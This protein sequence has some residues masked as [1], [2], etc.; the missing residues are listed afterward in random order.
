[1]AR[2]GHAHMPLIAHCPRA[3]SG[4]LMLRIGHADERL[5]RASSGTKPWHPNVGQRT[6]R[7]GAHGVR[8]MAYGRKTGGRDP[9]PSTTTSARSRVR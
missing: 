9:V 2:S 3:A 6:H 8:I 1:M 4:T 7:R 5:L